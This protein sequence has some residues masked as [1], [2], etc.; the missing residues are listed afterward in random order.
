[1]NEKIYIIGHYWT[2]EKERINSYDEYLGYFT[3][4]LD[5]AEKVQELQK[6]AFYTGDKVKYFYRCVSPAKI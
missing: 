4:D 3:N 2:D 5:A 1:M 6:T